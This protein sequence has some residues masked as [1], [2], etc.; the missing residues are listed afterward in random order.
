[1]PR[2][3]AALGYAPL[4]KRTML[5]QTLTMLNFVPLC[6]RKGCLIFVICLS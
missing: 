2:F 1:L 5:S 4:R 3:A 6:E